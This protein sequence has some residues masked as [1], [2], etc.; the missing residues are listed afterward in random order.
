[1]I[2]EDRVLLARMAE[3]NASMGQVVVQ[4][5][6]RLHGGSLDAADLRAVGCALTTLGTDMTQRATELDS[7]IINSTA[8][9]IEEN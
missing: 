1:M 8:L 2:D 7:P 6:S 4:M 3:V 5:M 9:E